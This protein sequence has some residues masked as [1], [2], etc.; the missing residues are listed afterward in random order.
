MK[1][2]RIERSGDKVLS[3]NDAPTQSLQTVLREQAS[4]Y[5]IADLEKALVSSYKSADVAQ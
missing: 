1:I 3:L 5:I 4:L 2:V